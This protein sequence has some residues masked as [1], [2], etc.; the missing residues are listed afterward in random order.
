MTK[1]ATNDI[2][3][4]YVPLSGISPAERNP[5]DHDV[6]AIIQSL[7]R[8]GFVAP[9]ILNETTG[10]I[11]V[12]H[13]RSEALLE[14][15]RSGSN[16]P[17]RINVVDDEWM[18]PI[19]RGVSFRSDSEAEAYLL[20][21]NQLTILGD[22]DNS[23]LAE[24]LKGFAEDGVDFEGSGFDED[25]LDQILK[26]LK[27]EA[28]KGEDVEEG[29]AADPAEELVEEWGV[30]L[31][32]TWEAGPHRIVCGDSMDSETVKALVGKCKVAMVYTDPPYGMDLDADFSSMVGLG[33]G[34]KYDNVIGDSEPYDPAHIF[35]DLGKCKEIFLWGADYYAE[36]VPDRVAGSWVVWDKVGVEGANDNYD[37]MFGSNFELCWSKAR[38]KRALVRVTWKG[39]FGL[40]E[41]DTKSR[42]HPTQKPAKLAAWF[43][44]KFSDHKDLIVD[45]F[46][47]SGSTIVAAEQMNRVCYGIEIEPKYVAVILQRLKDLGLDPALVEDRK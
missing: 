34:N 41:E 43:I 4:E 19:I 32:Q 26:D 44:E 33:K 16:P 3:V 17:E 2:R 37:K 21:D 15:K 5:K 42:V 23:Q 28:N 18:V 25:D 9:G 1:P 29:D 6:G 13:G 27:N 46:L 39:I 35:R 31:G 40:S 38:H 22:W 45:L 12:G 7:K 20:A 14:M 30:K 36:R 11:V 8:F 47:G 10:R 24:I